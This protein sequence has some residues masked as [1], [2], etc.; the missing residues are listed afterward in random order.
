[1]PLQTNASPT[2]LFV[3]AH[4][5]AGLT[6][7]IGVALPRLFPRDAVRRGGRNALTFQL[8]QELEVAPWLDAGTNATR[9]KTSDVHSLRH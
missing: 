6:W 1:M 5:H 7:I 2:T 8:P 9:D 4:L 3:R